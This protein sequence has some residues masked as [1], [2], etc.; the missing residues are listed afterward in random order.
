MESINPN[1]IGEL[2]TETISY[3]TLK[4]GNM[5]MIDDSVPEKLKKEKNIKNIEKL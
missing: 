1:D 4:N 2:D 5:V 3:I